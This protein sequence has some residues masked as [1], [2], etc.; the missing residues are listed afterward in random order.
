ML[1]R[2]GTRGLGALRS[3]LYE[4]PKSAAFGRMF[5]SLHHRSGG[6]QDV[7]PGHRL[8]RRFFSSPVE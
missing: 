7:E 8:L 3:P 6:G 1:V 2:L 5:N 4:T